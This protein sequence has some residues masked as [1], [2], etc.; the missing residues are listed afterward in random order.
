MH[1]PA[2][3]P[4]TTTSSK[5]R[6]QHREITI[7]GVVR[8]GQVVTF[9]LIVG[10]VFISV[11]LLVLTLSENRQA[12]P[13]IMLPAIGAT[14]GVVTWIVALVLPEMLR[15][16][17]GSKLA[18]RVDPLDRQA[19]NDE[20]LEPSLREFATTQNSATL[21]GQ[22]VLEGGAVTNLIL[23][24]MDGWLVLHLSFAAAAT[25]GIASMTPTTTKLRH[26][27]ERARL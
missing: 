26:A 21:I 4:Y 16:Q 5:R 17:A 6:R 22:A 18:A 25:I 19:A 2:R 15:S 1:D 24:F 13:S 27:I 7:H 23:M 12:D 9:A 11:T 14:V 10:I 3:N 8:T 20:T